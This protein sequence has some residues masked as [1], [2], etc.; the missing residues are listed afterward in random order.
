MSEELPASELCR[1]AMATQGQQLHPTTQAIGVQLPIVNFC[2]SVVCDFL[3]H[4]CVMQAELRFPGPH[5]AAGSSLSQ[6]LC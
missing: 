3:I 5:T 1:G 6:C 2:T 4:V